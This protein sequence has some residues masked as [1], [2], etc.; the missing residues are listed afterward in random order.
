MP[1]AGEFL[2]FIKKDIDPVIF[3]S[4]NSKRASHL[5][6]IKRRL[7]MGFYVLVVIMVG[8]NG[9]M[10]YFAITESDTILAVFTGFWALL[11][12][13]ILYETNKSRKKDPDRILWVWEWLEWKL[14][15]GFKER[16]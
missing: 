7:D 14:F 15:S 16:Q 13:S 1:N 9:L 2:E 12:V 5:K 4:V 3:E 8:I 6:R 11:T 10:A